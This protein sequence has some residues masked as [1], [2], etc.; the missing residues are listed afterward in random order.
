[1][2]AL[3]SSFI[4]SGVV[5]GHGPAQSKSRLPNP[6]GCEKHRPGWGTGLDVRPNP[7]I[8]FP[9]WGNYFPVTRPTPEPPSIRYHGGPAPGPIPYPGAPAYGAQLLDQAQG[10]LRLALALIGTRG[11]D[12]A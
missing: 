4:S 8:G 3:P 9:G 11:S 1:M 5:S 12:A 10:R 6:R 7:G 2:A